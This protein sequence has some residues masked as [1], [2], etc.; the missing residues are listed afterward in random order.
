[1]YGFKITNP[2][3]VL[4]VVAICDFVFYYLLEWVDVMAISTI[5]PVFLACWAASVVIPSMRAKD[6]G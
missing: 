6:D 5:G 2:I 4:A 1:M 3:G